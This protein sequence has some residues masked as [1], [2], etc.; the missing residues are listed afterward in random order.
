MKIEQDWNLILENYQKNVRRVGS[1]K[2]SSQFL[3]SLYKEVWRA[4]VI[5]PP[6]FRDDANSSSEEETVEDIKFYDLN[7]ILSCNIFLF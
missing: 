7:A 2:F 1:N 4:S 5:L 3:K 6:N